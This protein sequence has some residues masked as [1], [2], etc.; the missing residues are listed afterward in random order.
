[1]W[2]RVLAAV[3]TGDPDH[4]CAAVP[5]RGYFL[6]ALA[7]L[8]LD[9]SRDP[10]GRRCPTRSSD[11]LARFTFSVDSANLVTTMPA[12]SIP[13]SVDPTPRNLGSGSLSCFPISYGCWRF[14]GTDVATARAKIEAALEC[15]IN[16]IDTADCYG[17]PFG[18]S[19]ALLGE[20]FN[21]TPGLRDRVV[22][23]TKGG[24]VPG[25]PYDSSATHLRAAAEASL[26]RL[27]VD[28]LDLYQIHRPD[29]LG[30]PA[31]IA[32][33]LTDLR[34]SG[35]I[36]AAGV[37]NYTPAQSRALQAHLDF[38][39]VTQQPEF[40]CW[41]HAP[42]HDGVLDLCMESHMTPLAWSPLAGGRLGLDLAAARQ[43]PAGDRW[44]A[45][46]DQLDQ[47]ASAQE[48]TR[49]AVALAW[50]MLH[51]SGAIP[52]I[53]TQR[54]ERIQESVTALDVTMTRAQWNNILVAAAG[55]PLP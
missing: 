49:I 23:A 41:H 21:E 51:P 33:V 31:R 13:L 52:I 2:W 36:R 53:G 11:S 8:H 14:A 4:R 34:E 42:L 10:T 27:R 55:E 22:L 45:L 30:H 17:K 47:L 38:P 12:S 7:L 35:K 20:V 1:M 26:T 18:A 3:R 19:E 25:V 48:T 32:E 43:Q 44:T 16:L 5:G 24:V 37:S 54:I 6:V 39:L 50:V 15:G 46:L 28:V 9:D 40:S 29:F